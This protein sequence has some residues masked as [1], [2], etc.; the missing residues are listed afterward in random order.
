MPGGVTV[1]RLTYLPQTGENIENELEIA[2][3]EYQK[4]KDDFEILDDS[5]K[6]LLA[7]LKIKII[8]TQEVSDTRAESLARASKDWTD[9]KEGLYVAKRL[10]GTKSAR[11]KHLQRVLDLLINGLSFE[12]AKLMKGL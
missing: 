6:D 11:Y 9:F 2:E 8:S 3:Q 4:A 1:K 12:K 7:T 10:Y 5:G